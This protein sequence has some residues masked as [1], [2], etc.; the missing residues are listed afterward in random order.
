MN[1]PWR[2]PMCR[3]LETTKPPALCKLVELLQLKDCVVTADALHCHRRDGKKPSWE[4]GG[5]YVLAVKN[6]QPGLLRD[7]KTAIAAAERKKTKTSHHQGRRSRP[8]GKPEP[9]SLFPSRIWPKKHNFPGLKAVARI[10]SKTWKRRDRRALL[11]LWTQPLQARGTAA[12]RSRTL[13]YRKTSCTGTLDVV[14]D[15]DQDAKP[16]RT[17]PPANLAVYAPTCPSILARAHP[18]TKNLVAG[19]AQTARPGTT[20]FLVDMLLKHAIALPLAGRGAGVG[21]HEHSV[22]DPPTPT[23]PPQG[24]RE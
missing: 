16:K 3:H 4:R 8:Q 7:A 13:G 18:D 5:D 14:L 2:L 9:R 21:V 23:P 19:Q 6:N 17:M 12:H 20:K 22:C 10:T 15:E 1:P 24:G 11:S